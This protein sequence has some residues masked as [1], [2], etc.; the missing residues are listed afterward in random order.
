[1]G[2]EGA[3]AWLFGVLRSRGAGAGSAVE[4]GVIGALS[5]GQ[6]APN[7]TTTVMQCGRRRSEE[8]AM[9]AAQASIHHIA[10]TV[11]DL[12]ASIRWYEQVFGVVYQMDAPHPGGVGKVARGRVVAAS[13]R[14][15]PARHAR[16]RTLHRN[17][18]GA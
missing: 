4:R 18:D 1:M 14:L 10:L 7:L 3:A 15:A 9:P 11:T 8:I 16:S 12:D 17:A 5:T 2:S 6:N 13:D